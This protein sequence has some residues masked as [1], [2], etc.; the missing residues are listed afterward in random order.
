MRRKSFAMI[1]LVML[2]IL[3]VS[4]GRDAAFEQE[5]EATETASLKSD[6]YIVVGFSQ[7][8]AESDWRSANTESMKE[9]FT[10]ENG[11][12]L[13]LRGWTAETGKPDCCHP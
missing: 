11:Y 8:G 9:T 4:C 2:C 6:R 13:N 1:M 3:M 10:T 7:L 12:K 5:A